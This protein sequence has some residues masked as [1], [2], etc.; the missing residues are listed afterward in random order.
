MNLPKI[1][2]P[3]QYVGL[4]VV[5]FGEDVEPAGRCC[6]GYTTEEVAAL[7]ESEPYQ[8]I[9]VYR[10]HRAK[11]DGT[12]ELEGAPHERFQLESCMIFHCRDEDVAA[13]EYQQVLD[14]AQDN[15]CPCRAQWRMAEAFGGE[16]V[17]ALIYPAEYEAQIGQWMLDSGFRG[18]GAV[19]AGPSMAALY[20]QQE[21]ACLKKEQLWPELALRARDREELIAAV[22]QAIQR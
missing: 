16:L 4:Y 12:M 22:G 20:R 21:Q 10:I 13:A 5:D 15:A 17:L 1:D 14:W 2:M 19:D 7:L 6:V 9:K 8:H 3:E 18:H 11:P